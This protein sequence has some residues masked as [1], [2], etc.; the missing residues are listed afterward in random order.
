MSNITI[1][2]YATPLLYSQTEFLNEK[3]NKESIRIFM[4]P[5]MKDN[6]IDKNFE[7]FFID[8]TF[9]SVPVG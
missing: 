9:D 6:L 7:H 8:G 4:D 2:S 1:N 3:G 5:S